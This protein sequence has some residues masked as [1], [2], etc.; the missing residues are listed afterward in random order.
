MAGGDGARGG[1]VARQQ[2]RPGKG[3][4]LCAAAAPVV[5]RVA[6]TPPPTR[7]AGS[8]QQAKTPARPVAQAPGPPRPQP[9]RN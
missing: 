9:R 5:A 4:P 1:Q 6:P 8:A 3:R 2:V 7:P